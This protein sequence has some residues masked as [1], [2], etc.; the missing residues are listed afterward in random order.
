MAVTLTT[1]RSKLRDATEQVR[2]RVEALKH[3][4]APE[5]APAPKKAR[6]DK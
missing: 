1:K 3:Q 2:Q 6:K 5:Q 4:P